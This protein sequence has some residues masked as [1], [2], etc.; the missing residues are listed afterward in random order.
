MPTFFPNSSKKKDTWWETK[1]QKSPV[2]RTPRDEQNEDESGE[3]EYVWDSSDE[4]EEG[5][6]K[7]TCVGLDGRRRQD[8]HNR[9][10]QTI[11]RM[12]HKDP[13][14]HKTRV[15]LGTPNTTITV[16]QAPNHYFNKDEYVDSRCHTLQETDHVIQTESLLGQVFV[17]STASDGTLKH[18]HPHLPSKTNTH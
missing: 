8:R 9:H 11:G 14:K 15:P 17:T 13:I 12:C 4:Q 16:L 3:I 5:D 1:A 18:R 6:T 7:K 10:P 2:T